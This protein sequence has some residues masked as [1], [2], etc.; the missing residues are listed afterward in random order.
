MS[1]PDFSESPWTSCVAA[2]APLTAGQTCGVGGGEGLQPAPSRPPSWLSAVSRE[3]VDN[4]IFMTGAWYSGARRGLERVVTTRVSAVQIL[5]RWGWGRPPFAGRGAAL[6]QNGLRPTQ[7]PP[8]KADGAR[9][10]FLSCSLSEGPP[11][12]CGEGHLR[13]T[14]GGI[15]QGPT[16]PDRPA[17]V[18]RMCFLYGLCLSLRFSCLGSRSLLWASVCILSF[19]YR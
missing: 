15:T 9:S 14:V 16:W 12:F 13:G 4:A 6:R 19:L 11:P 8:G 18:S 3:R 10:P 7:V 1:G 17:R 2:R 5:R